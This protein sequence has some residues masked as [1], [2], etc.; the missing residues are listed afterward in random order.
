M[1]Q[2]RGEMTELQIRGRTIG[3]AHPPLVVAEMLR[4]IQVLNQ[5]KR[6]T[7]LLVEQHVS[8]ALALATTAYVLENGRVVLRGSA[9]DLANNPHVKQAY[10]GL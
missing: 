2:A 3:L 4:T 5:E 8:H 9:A 1:N 7:V 10:L 6:M